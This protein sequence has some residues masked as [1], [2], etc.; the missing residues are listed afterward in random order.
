METMAFVVLPKETDALTA[1]VRDLLARLD[2][3]PQRTVTC[4]GE[5]ADYLRLASAEPGLFDA[6]R[7]ACLAGRIAPAYAVCPPAWET[8][9]VAA[10]AAKA[11]AEQTF[12]ET[13]LGRQ[14]ETALLLPGCRPAQLPQLLVKCGLRFCILP[15][16]T[17]FPAPAPFFWWESADGARVLTACEGEAVQPPEAAGEAALAADD[18]FRAQCRLPLDLPTLR[19]APPAPAL[20][21]LP[22]PAGLRIE[23]AGIALLDC[24]LAPAESRLLLAETAGNAVAAS[25]VCAAP[26]FGFYADFT[27]YEIKM[28][29]IGPDGFAAETDFPVP[30]PRPAA[31]DD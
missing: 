18:W 11:Q 4:A 3:A 6:V 21:G 23:G 26:P 19:E 12:F 31:E 7:T 9:A 28:F 2:A 15:G 8:A 22:L 24:A 17:D 1:C 30:Q 25:V 16:E 27:P 5:C 14:C 29:R 13:H 10:F 20:Q